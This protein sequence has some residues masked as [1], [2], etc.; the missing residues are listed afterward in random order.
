M[1]FL[2]YQIIDTVIGKGS[3]GVVK[4]GFDSKN[5]SFVAVKI[6][7]DDVKDDILKNE[8]NIIKYMNSKTSL[9]L[10]CHWAGYVDNKY[11][12]ITNL[13]GVSLGSLFKQS[14]NSFPLKSCAM[15]GEKIINEIRLIH[16]SNIIHRDIK[17]DNIMFDLEGK[18]VH[19]IDFGLSTKFRRQSKTHI[20]YRINV[21]YIGTLRYM[22]INAHERKEQ[23]RRDDMY[24]IGYVLLYLITGTLPWIINKKTKMSRS[25]KYQHVL[26]GKK[27]LKLNDIRCS[28]CDGKCG[29]VCPCVIMFSNYFSYLDSLSFEEPINYN[30]LIR[31]LLLCVLNHQDQDLE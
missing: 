11:H 17:P 28:D 13:Y 1:S 12:M 27:S 29:N 5:N 23:S 4:L 7:N 21:P 14:N 8:A 19:L 24:S 31:E 9:D 18:L 15:I 2:N 22:S 16:N 3:F 10:K 6:Q 30:Y 25:E 26:N 20:P